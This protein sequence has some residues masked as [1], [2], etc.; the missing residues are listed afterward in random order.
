MSTTVD[1]RVVE[2]RFDNK[3]F[4]SNVS[5]TMS[6]LDKLKQ[7]LNLTG[8]AKGLESVGTAAKGVNMLGL[9]SAVETVQAKFS[10]LQ[11]AGVTALANITNS[12]VNTGKRMIS[13]LTIDPIKTGFSEYETQIN[14]VQT[15]LANTQSK[16]KT[17]TDVNGALDE[18]NAYADKTIYNFTEMTRNIGTFTAAGVDLDKSVTSI[19]GIAN[20]A[21]VS[22][23]NSQQAS[24]AMYQLSQA[25]ASGTVK[26]MDW[27]SVVNAGMGGQ[28][29]Q[30]ALKNTSKHMKENAKN[31]KRMSK[32][33]RQ[34]YQETH[35]YTDEQ[36]KSMMAY[37]YNVD[38]II[39]KN[40]SFRESLQ[41][42]WLTADVLTETLTQL[43]GA[44]TEADLVAQGYTEE[45]AKEI[46]KLA[47]TAVNAATKVKTFTQ[48]WD[49]LKEAA[50]SGWTQSWEIIVGDFEEAKETLTK[51][52]DTIGEM[53][54]ASSESRNKLLQGWKDGGGRDSLLEGLKNVFYGIKGIIVPIQKAFRDIFPPM[55]VD[56]ILGV[57]KAFEKLSF[58]FAKFTAGHEAEFKSIFKGIFSIFDIGRKVVTAFAK[59]IAK[60]LGSDGV[61]KVGTFIF[62]G[63]VS[64]GEY[65]TKLNENFDV[66]G[67]S[68]IFS[69]IAS[70][71]SSALGKSVDVLKG[72]GSALSTIG[73]FIVN[74]ASKIWNG[75]KIAFNW[76]SENV[77]MDDVFAGLAG[78][79][80]FVLAKKL[81]GFVDGIKEAFDGLFG[82]GEGGDS[83]KEKF[84][85]LLDGVG[86][87]IQS[88]ST[89][90]KVGSF[91]A[92]AAAIAILASAFGKISELD[93]EDI[94]KSLVTMGVSLGIMMKA[95][96]SMPTN[97]AFATSL[98][99]MTE[100]TNLIKSGIALMMLAKSI[101]ILS[102]AIL[103]LSDLSWEEIAKGL[104]GV[105]GGIGAL[106]GGLKILNGTK[107]SLG[108]SI[109]MLA[110]AEACKILGDAMQ[111]FVGFSWDEI[112]R[113][114]VG[115]GFA[116]GE[117]VAALS[118]LSKVGGFGALLGG[119]GILI[120]VQSLSDMAEALKEFGS[121]NWDEI[122][123]GLAG[124]G[125]ALGELAIALGVLSKISTI[126]I[127][128]N[129]G[130]GILGKLGKIGGS[131]GF[132]ATIS[133]LSTMFSA[134][135][136]W[137]AIQGL[138]DLANALKDFGSMSWPEIGA[139]IVAMG[140][141]LGEVAG[142][143]GALGK[144]AGFS[145]IF[146]AGA[147]WITI[148]GLADLADSFKQFGS[149][150]WEQIVFAFDGMGMALMEV[151][152]VT[153]S[154]GKLAG[155][156]GLLGGGAL[157]IAV[158]SLG[159]LAEAMQ[160]FGSMS[161]DEIGR[162]LTAMGFA[163]LE[164]AGITGALGALA[165]LPALLGGGAILLAVQG[166]GDLADALKKFGEMS[167]DEIGR[168]LTAM[169]AALGEVALGGL[170]NTL[171]GFGAA[172]ISE[173][174]APLG[175][176][177]DS[178]KKWSGVS[179]PED[180]SA[181]LSSLASGVKAFTFGGWGAGAL[182]EAAPGVGTMADS[183][184]KW[185]GVS[186]PEDLGTSLET[187]AS[188]VKAFTF[189]GFGAGALTEAAPGV[190]TMADSVKKWAGVTIPENLGTSLQTLGSGVKAFTFGG[191]GAGNLAEAAP[192]VATMADSV[193]KWAGVTVPEELATNLSALAGGVKA[194]TFGGSG[195]GSLAEAAPG[196]GTL[197]DSV[198]KWTNVTIPE[199]LVT[200]LGTLA[201]GVKKFTFGGS[202]AESIATCAS[203]LGVM[204][205]SVKKWTGLT[206]PE[207]LGT[208]MSTLASGV[209]SFTFGGSGAETLTTAAAG[210]GAMAD[211]VKKWSGVTI[212]E[213]F[214]T[215]LNSLSTAIKDISGVGDISATAA[216]LGDLATNA[217]K[218]AGVAFGTIKDGLSNLGT[219]ISDLSSASSSI[220]G[221]G[222]K[223]YNEIVTPLKNTA[224][225]L[226][227]V[228]TDM[229]SSIANGLTS[230]QGN[231]T[232][233]ASSVATSISKA[234]TG[235]A[236]EFSTA[237]KT[238]MAK[239]AS[240]IESSGSKVTSAAKSATS[241]AASGAKA[242]Y[243]SMYQAGQYLGDGLVA[244][245]NAMQT[246]AYNAGFALGQAAVQGEKDG[247]ESASPSKATIKAGK[248]L[249]EGLVIGIHRMGK[250][251][252]KAGSSMGEDAVGAISGSF[253]KISDAFNNNVDSQPTIRPI[254]D[255]S[256]VES[257]ANTISSLFGISPSV[258]V[259]ANVGA[260]NTMMNRRGQNGGNDDVVSAIGKLRRDIANMPRESYNINGVTYDDGSNIRGFAEAVVHQARLERRV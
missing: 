168:G 8:A 244:G 83:I 78:G 57:T 205:D 38:N 37:N 187:L 255:L 22:G 16:G 141:A 152:A 188:G 74:V 258:G 201:D 30:D 34:A 241:K 87:S 173:M 149:M 13:A 256:D 44:Y 165:G 122:G 76:I 53:I 203:G 64:I 90:V 233:T 214:S 126:S 15:I 171:S 14:A 71:I 207:D 23:S 9:G 68:D 194:F 220:S 5:N 81:I 118:V 24:T 39:K 134:G 135:A 223:I 167:W 2:M 231:V 229:I 72:F 247:Q 52:S 250:S 27:N 235:K 225:D 170:L 116:L 89:G 254:L 75:L 195:A 237:G 70:G 222:T 142:I 12:A 183:V 4:E 172:A 186:V 49:T 17:I 240:G 185:S 105:G 145:S 45:Q 19:K 114:L 248:W 94:A 224:T 153:G 65:F 77:S 160:S 93:A 55:T 238:L 40:G 35:G 146:G 113:G 85:E 6:T 106:C 215:N 193:A 196:I 98:F 11:V 192:G 178:V 21:A 198:V 92:I 109:A 31:L 148:Q 61:S 84:I 174:A 191:N 190:G 60:L 97:K 107:V 54:N 179:V 209:K 176:L 88:F 154:L 50:Q 140:G 33:Q 117:L 202:G 56:K 100:N 103:K 112:G 230:G 243:S 129:I 128:G 158:Q 96:N 66:D 110:L 189:G 159:D 26:L 234:I 218:L 18:L 62:D 102:N 246:A 42:G 199:G 228:G 236:N 204:A 79:S 213:G 119:T 163:L 162:G 242:S 132:S 221:V 115:M 249:G 217:S 69:S 164:V 161:W 239:L 232:K 169:G 260:V 138:K 259:L 86:E 208:N 177:A 99:G 253:G 3:Q 226:K 133:G 137:I 46:V 82:K 28:V 36:M 150:S 157:L 206:V 136:I 197:A 175:V 131:G 120:A 125:G 104:V 212:P 48:L 124:M 144:L 80:I 130:G 51:V 7:K 200:N 210:V 63:L 147:I 123:R 58:S 252:Y 73:D 181:N 20:L 180:L 91:V 227:S 143:T 184:K 67:V 251:V 156:S 127:S 95:I 139:G 108:T 111:K 101:D 41:E 29:F 47:D 151:A 257:G 219:A 155:F 166:L 182:A 211:S 216:G 43:S 10:A 1:Q 121:M 32:A 25:L 245:I 59:S